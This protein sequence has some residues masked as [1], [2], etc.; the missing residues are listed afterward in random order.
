MNVR[1]ISITGTRRR[2]ETPGPVGY[3]AV[4]WS[5]FVRVDEPHGRLAGQQRAAFGECERGLC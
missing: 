4:L 3:F 5:R 2:L 1:T